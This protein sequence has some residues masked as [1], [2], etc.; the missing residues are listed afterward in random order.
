MLVY[1]PGIHEINDL[2]LG[3]LL[4]HP[5]GIEEAVPDP[6]TFFLPAC[7]FLAAVLEISWSNFLLV[8]NN[9]V[10]PFT[11][12][13]KRLHNYGKSPCYQW[14]NPLFRLRHFQELCGCLPEGTIC[15][16]DSCL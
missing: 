10:G 11:W 15:L 12:P 8:F 16:G 5:G 1:I 13:G 9:I 7:C 3:E 14:V 6:A 4:D 2:N